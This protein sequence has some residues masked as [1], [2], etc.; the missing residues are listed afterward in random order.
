MVVAYD[1]L[2]CSAGV[3]I[4]NL[5]RLRGDDTLHGNLPRL[6]SSF[7]LCC[8]RRILLSCNAVQR[9]RVL[10]VPSR[11]VYVPAVYETCGCISRGMR[12]DPDVHE[13][14]TGR[15]ETGMTIVFAWD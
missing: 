12:G 10:R 11:E 8:T 6:H 4:L 13:Q 15:D 1:W 2:T 9:H 14:G 3:Q 5:R 7:S